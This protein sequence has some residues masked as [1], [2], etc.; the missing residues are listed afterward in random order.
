MGVSHLNALIGNR[1]AAS[2][3]VHGRNSPNVSV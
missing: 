3:F 2:V 1:N